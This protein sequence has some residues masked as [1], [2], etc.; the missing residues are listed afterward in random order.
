MDPTHILTT[1]CNYQI[2]HRLWFIRDDVIKWKRFPRYWPFPGKSPAS[3]E[4]PTQRPVTQSFDVFSDLRMNKRFSKQSSG[5]WFE[6]NARHHLEHRVWSTAPTKRSLVI[7]IYIYIYTRVLMRLQVAAS[8]RCI[9]LQLRHNWRDGVSKH[10][11]LDFLLNRLFRRRSKKTSSSASL[12]F[13]RGIHG[14]PVDS[15]PKRPVTRK[16][17]SFDGVIM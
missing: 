2:I 9:P 4:F 15:T 7:Y 11:R 1:T 17:F 3:G 5:W 8:Q 10:W 12:A 16:M 14:R 6:S 13:A